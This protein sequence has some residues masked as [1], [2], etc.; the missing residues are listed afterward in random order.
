MIRQ[1]REVDFG[2]SDKCQFLIGMIRPFNATFMQPRKIVSIPYRYDTATATVTWQ[3][4]QVSIPYRYDMTTVFK[5][6][7]H[8]LSIQ[9]VK[10]DIK[11]LS[12]VCQPLSPLYPKSKQNQAFSNI[13]QFLHLVDRLTNIYT[14]YNLP[15]H[16]CISGMHVPR[17]SEAAGRYMSAPAPEAG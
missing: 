4:T 11:S 12:K 2:S 8:W 1:A 9:I 13:R 14:A 6:F 16:G 15:P 5:P 10:N 3:R 17:A 7:L